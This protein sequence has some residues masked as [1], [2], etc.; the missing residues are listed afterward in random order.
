MEVERE[1][2]EKFLCLLFD[3]A[4]AKY[5]EHQARAEALRRLQTGDFV[6][7]SVRESALRTARR[8]AASSGTLAALVS[9]GKLKIIAAHYDLDTGKVEYLTA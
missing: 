9:A 3:P 8:L 2:A 4:K 7:N 5:P 6:D 1:F